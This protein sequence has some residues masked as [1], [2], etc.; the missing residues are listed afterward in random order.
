MLY[1]VETEPLTKREEAELEAAASKMLRF[2]MG[3]TTMDKCKMDNIRG[4]AH[5]GKIKDE[6]RETKDD[7]KV[8]ELTEE[9]AIDQKR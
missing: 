8:V 4:T 7:F 5:V 2:S 3:V 9:D 6:L 1:W